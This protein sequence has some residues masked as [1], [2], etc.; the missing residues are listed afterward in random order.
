MVK[1]S[2]FGS[3]LIAFL[4]AHSA[5][6]Q[7]ACGPAAS[8]R[9]QWIASCLKP[10]PAHKKLPGFVPP[11]NEQCSCHWDILAKAFPPQQHAIVAEYVEALAAARGRRN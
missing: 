10:R 6:A 1:S 7:P 3:V 11:T 9:C 8:P 5:S 4:A 2:I